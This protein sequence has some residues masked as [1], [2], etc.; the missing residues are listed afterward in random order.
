MY[1]P[2]FDYVRPTS[3]QEAI[4]VLQEREEAKLLA[5]GHSLIPLLKLRTASVGTLVDIGRLEDLK[6]VQQINGTVRVGPVSTHTE[7]SAAVALPEAL[8]EAAA[9]VG[10]RQVRNRGTIGG[11][12]AHADPASDL[13]T[14]LTALGAAF[15]CLGPRGERTVTA[16]DFFEGWFMTALGEHELLTGLFV[17]TR[18]PAT[19]TAYVK[20]PHPA[21]GYAIL[22]AAAS[23]TMSAGRCTSAGVAV[24]GLTPKAMRAPSVEAAL[25]GKSPD[26]SLISAAAKAVVDDLGDDL[27]GD[28]FASAEYRRAI[29]PVY[30]ERA[31]TDALGRARPS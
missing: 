31:L 15:R 19:G 12:V 11:N 8:T 4:S 13:P 6:G 14:V 9:N 2:E 25:V 5:G 21:S 18:S 22:G 30:V 17:P 23:L 27:L 28:T 1:P 3:V 7:I 26:A 16:A 24:G 10:D 29:L 20:L